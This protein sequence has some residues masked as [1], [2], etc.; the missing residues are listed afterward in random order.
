MKR[1]TIFG[2]SFILLMLM[3]LSVFSIEYPNKAIEFIIPFGPGGSTDFTARMVG[4]KAA[5][6][7]GVPMVYKNMP[8][9]GT[10][11]AM[12]YLSRAP[13]DGYTF[14]MLCVSSIVAMLTTKDLDFQIDDF[15]PIAQINGAPLVLITK[16]GRFK[17]F[18][19]FINQAKENP[20]Q[21]T[22]ASYGAKGISHL[23]GEL[24]KKEAGID[25]IHV[26]FA[27]GAE[28]LVAV[29]G[30]HVDVGIVTSTTALSN[31]EAGELTAL[32]LDTDERFDKLP[33]VPTY[34]ELGYPDI[35]FPSFD[36]LCMPKG[37]P[38]EISNILITA[39]EEAITDE[40][41]QIILE[42]GGT[43]PDFVSHQEWK[44][45]LEEI[46]SIWDDLI[47]EIGM[48]EE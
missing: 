17:D 19:D 15:L 38:D 5:E 25:M 2:I 31:I 27:G 34:K 13:K 14:G 46:V 10:L 45:D 44:K 18:N 4:S 8:G 3:S 40:S 47:A 12:E 1:L 43:T 9:A 6:I 48:R 20:G 39:L 42:R 22:Y 41:I 30:E 36:G 23:G 16:P 29:L 24:L 28:A 32:A 33:D 37:V 35:K 26:P 7:L 21:I 11:V